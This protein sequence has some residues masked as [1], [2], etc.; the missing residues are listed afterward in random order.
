M[1]E[2]VAE[3]AHGD[4]NRPRLLLITPDFPPALGGI[5]TMTHRL[6]SAMSGFRTRVLTLD[7]AAATAFDERSPLDVRRVHGAWSQRRV[8]NALLNG[9]ALREAGRF[10]PDATLSM[11][12][13]TSP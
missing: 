12:I 9:A 7:G 8:A 3:S 1:F 10:R 5:Q 11:H 6:A 13:V 4:T 2:H